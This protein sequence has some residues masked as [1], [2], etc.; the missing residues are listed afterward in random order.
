VVF[1][2]VTQREQERRAGG[3]AEQINEATAAGKNS[4]R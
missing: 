2:S 4:E 3:R 1:N